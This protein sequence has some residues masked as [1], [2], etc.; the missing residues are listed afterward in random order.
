[1]RLGEN[2]DRALIV[3]TRVPVPGETKTRLMPYLSGK[4]CAEFHKACLQDVIQIQKM[5]SIPT[6]VFYSGNVTKD[7]IRLFP[8]QTQ[9]L[10]QTGQDLGYRMAN[11][12]AHCLTLHRRVVMIGSDLPNLPVSFLDQAF[13]DLEIN[14]VVLGPALDGGY[15]LIGVKKLYPALFSGIAW[16]S[17]QVLERTLQIMK[18]EK[19]A[20]TLLESM[21]DLDRIEDLVTFMKNPE[22]KDTHAWQYIHKIYPQRLEED[23]HG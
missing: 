7:F 19:L 13:N 9:F 2:M 16:G 4:E 18:R 20:Y 5:L 8:I 11:A 17:S 1:M 21:Q 15:Y 12:F 14:D 10:P 23:Y 3:M 6:Y 22:N